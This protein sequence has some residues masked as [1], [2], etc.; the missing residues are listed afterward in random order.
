ME[1][2]K[3]DSISTLLLQI[4]FKEIVQSEYLI[5]LN[6]YS[7]HSPLVRQKTSGVTILTQL[8]LLK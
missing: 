5:V 3:A 1:I 4:L 6:L 8:P 2:I 7:L